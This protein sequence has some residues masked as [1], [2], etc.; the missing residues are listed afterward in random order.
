MF[1]HPR[2]ERGTS[3]HGHI[4]DKTQRIP[5]PLTLNAEAVPSST[6]GSMNKTSPEALLSGKASVG[7]FVCR[8]CY[9]SFTTKE[10]VQYHVR[11][12]RSCEPILRSLRRRVAYRKFRPSKGLGEHTTVRSPATSNAGQST[13]V[14]YSSFQ[15]AAD[16]DKGKDNASRTKLPVQE[17]QGEWSADEDP[18]LTESRLKVQSWIERSSCFTSQASTSYPDSRRLQPKEL[19]SLPLPFQRPNVPS[20]SDK[21]AEY[22][23]HLEVVDNSDSAHYIRGRKSAA[24]VA[25]TPE[26]SFMSWEQLWAQVVSREPSAHSPDFTDEQFR[27]VAPE[28]L[29][30]RGAADNPTEVSQKMRVRDIRSFNRISAPL[31]TRRRAGG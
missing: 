23:S 30:L 14:Y 20:A 16:T 1:R 6:V 12:A 15:G 25:R 24:P 18:I 29:L 4:G 26:S 5:T 28:D 27:C 2:I 10:D 22:Y 13:K 8:L 3:G 19:P 7:R 21:V 11:D 9:Q 31:L 17:I